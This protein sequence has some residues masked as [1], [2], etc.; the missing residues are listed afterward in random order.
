MAVKPPFADAVGGLI[1]IYWIFPKHSSLHPFPHHSPLH[2]LAQRG[3]RM[4]LR[5]EEAPSLQQGRW[6]GSLWEEQGLLL[7]PGGMRQE[8]PGT[9]L[10]IWQVP[11]FSTLHLSLA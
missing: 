1:G 10:G 7:T 8:A 5:T 4:P 3:V 2:T 9:D 11:G 6:S